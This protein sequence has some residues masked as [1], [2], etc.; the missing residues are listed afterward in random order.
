MT[1]DIRHFPAILAILIASL[2]PGAAS[3]EAVLRLGLLGNKYNKPYTGGVVGF[4]QERQVFEQALAKEGVRIEWV[5]FSSGAPAV[6]EAIANGK[7]DLAVYGDVGSVVGRA[8]GLPTKVIAPN[9]LGCGLNFVLVPTTSSLQ[10]PSDLKGHRIAL[11]RATA[12]QLLFFR[13]I[14]QAGLSEKDV[15]IVNLGTADQEAAFVSGGVDI[16]IGN[17]LDLVDR[18]LARVLA[19]ID[20]DSVKSLA[21]FGNV[22]ATESFIHDHPRWIQA[23]MD[24]YVATS[25]SVLDEKFRPEF[26]RLATKTGTGTKSARISLPR[27]IEWSYAPV[28]DRYYFARL[29][30]AVADCAKYGI[31]ARAFEPGSWVDRSFLDVSLKTQPLA[32]RWLT[33]RTIPDDGK[34]AQEIR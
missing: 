6:N 19:T 27:N 29:R 2:L 34:L 28:F 8:G 17:S 5:F 23:W 14:R 31:S 11:T 13:W 33:L 22:V 20:A 7:L 1:L 3:A 16:L 9:G 21:G 24:A 32:D 4:A 30:D 15:R 18:G 10:T 25:A 12:P 26:V